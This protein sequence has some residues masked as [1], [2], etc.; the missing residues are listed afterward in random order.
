MT[1]RRCDTAGDQNSVFSM[2][3]NVLVSPWFRAGFELLVVVAPC[4]APHHD[5]ST[6]VVNGIY[7]YREIVIFCQ[8]YLCGEVFC[9]IS[10]VSGLLVANA[11]FM[12]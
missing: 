6:V 1:N 9:Q 10:T 12:L 7:N 8:V 11:G 5:P 2:L 4:R 3:L